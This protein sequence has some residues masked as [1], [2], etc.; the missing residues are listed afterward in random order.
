MKQEIQIEQ[1]LK[2]LLENAKNDFSAMDSLLA[3]YSDLVSQSDLAFIENYADKIRELCTKWE[4]EHAEAKGIKLLC[5]ML[6]D[7]YSTNFQQVL[8]VGKEVMEILK[9]SK[10][11]DF[12]GLSCMIF[13]ANNRSLGNLDHA[14]HYLIKGSEIINEDGKLSI[15]KCYS[16]YQ[17]AEINTSINDY[18]SA[19]LYYHKAVNLAERLNSLPGLFRTYNG[20]A[21]FY[22]SIQN[23]EECKKYLDLS[24]NVSGLSPSQQSRTR[25]DLGTYYYEIQDFEKSEEILLENYKTRIEAGLEDA[26][27]TSLIALAKTQIQLG[28]HAQAIENL[29]AAK[30]ITE[31]FNSK[32]KM[33]Q[34]YQLLS[35]VYRKEQQWEKAVEAYHKYDKMQSEQLQ[36][37]FHNIYKIKNQQI[38]NQKKIIEDFYT[39]VQDSIRYAKRIQSA[40]L[41]SLKFVKTHLPESFVLYKPKDII[42]G[43]F[44]WMEKTA[45]NWQEAVGKKAM[46]SPD[47]QSKIEIK[48]GTTYLA[49]A[50]CTGHGVPGALVSVVCNNALNRSVREFGITDPGEILSKTRELVV[51]EFE[52]SVEDVKDG[53]DISLVALAHSAKSESGEQVTLLQWAGANNPL[54][55]VSKR[56][57][58]YEGV[59]RI[60]E[61]D[62]YFLH[63]VPAD[64]QPI[65]KYADPKPFTSHQIPLRK[66]ETFYMFSDGYSDQFG[67]ENLTYRKVGGKKFKSTNFKKLF[68][69]IQAKPMENQREIIDTVFEDWRGDLEQLDDVCVI[70]VRV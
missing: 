16:Y 53:M 37:Q 26:A 13:G 10:N 67:G 60:I 33:L 47:D 51:Q 57:H 68:L 55:I 30:A 2:T 19:E 40:I 31:K 41:P 52:K 32:T 6:T 62:G 7:F 8:V 36:K 9:S 46:A 12:Y 35:D 28:K 3:L 14:V 5:D 58:V 64:K 4:K 22:L 61:Q 15:Y 21:N 29:V 38:K 70:G 66:G 25:C 56:E 65:G 43:D 27:S 48:G 63:E 24:L 54:W 45:G 59:K 11:Q 50:D 18:E 69:S 49:A 23:Y 42:A 17:L 20:L 34:C 39:E 1:Q 44:Y